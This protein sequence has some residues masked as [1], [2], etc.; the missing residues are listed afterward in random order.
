MKLEEVRNKLLAEVQSLPPE[1]A[2]EFVNQSLR[3]IYKER[4]WSFLYKRDLLRTPALINTGTVAVE[5]FSTTVVPSAA[6]KAILDA[7]TV[8]DVKLEGRQFRT[9]GGTIAGSNFIYTIISYDS[10]GAGALTIDPYYQDETNSVATFQIFKNLYTAQELD[11]DFAHFEIIAAPFNQRRLNL[12][13]TRSDLDARDISRTAMG[14]PSYAVPY[15]GDSS[16][17]QLIELYPIPINKRVYRTYFKREGLTLEPEDDIPAKLPYELVVAN[18]KIKA[19]EWLIINGESVGVK[20][21][22]NTFLNMIGMLN[23]PDMENS[24]SSLL[25]K[26]KLQDENLLPQDLITMGDWPYY[27]NVVVETVLLDF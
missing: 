26:A 8:N 22:P 7:I 14:D 24:Y 12:D 20:K 6:L 11:I 23:N 16:E 18:A 5:E 15:I 21:S 13:L 4:D 17:N 10:S 1:L 2:L 3:D 19:Y 25:K 27:E 9:F